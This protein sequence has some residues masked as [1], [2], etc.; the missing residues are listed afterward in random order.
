MAEIAEEYQLQLLVYDRWR[1][2]DFRRELAKFQCSRLVKASKICRQRSIRLSNMW[3]SESCATAATRSLTCAQLERLRK[4]ILRAI[5]N[6][7]N[8]KATQR[9]MGWWRWPWRLVLCLPTKSLV[10]PV[11]GMTPNLNWPCSAVG[12]QPR[13]L[14][15]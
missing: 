2:N 12:S 9:L 7:K 6:C 15:Q 14:S 10:Q 5:A 13:I 4:A 3:Q 11:H 1:I 8:Q